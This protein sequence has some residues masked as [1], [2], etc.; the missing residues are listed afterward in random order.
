MSFDFHARYGLFT[1]AQS[2]GLDP[3]AVSNHFTELGAE[4]IVAEEAHVDG[5]THLHVFA[6]WGR[7]RRYRRANTFDVD[8][9]H[10][11]I[12]ASRG[13][14]AAGWD[15]TTK[16]GNVVAGGLGRPSESCDGV[17][18]KDA[19]WHTI[20]DACTREQFFEL[21]RELAPADLAK[22]YPSLCRYADFRYAP[23][24][25]VYS[26][27]TRDD[28]R[29]EITQYPDLV[30]WCQGF[31]Q[32]SDEQLGEFCSTMPPSPGPSRDHGG[33]SG[34]LRLL[35]LAFA[36]LTFIQA[37]ADPSSYGGQQ[38]WENPLGLEPWDS[39]YTLLDYSAEQQLFREA[40]MPNTPSSMTSE[41]ESNSSLGSRIGLDASPVS[42]SSS[43]TRNQS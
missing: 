35:S 22:S 6:D 24:S 18:R 10:P 36:R 14:P 39:T 21:V 8:N 31:D 38:D 11:N 26:G 29:F 41:E 42:W 19:I 30:E 15:Y 13:T 16:D 1:Y 28:P 7:R 40:E 34:G 9:F 37:E 33:P 20:M 23:A 27:P 25:P 4:C 32:R 43:Y 5:G 12:V 3:W 2:D 17:L